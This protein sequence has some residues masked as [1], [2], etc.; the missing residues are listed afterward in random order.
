MTKRGDTY[1]HTLLVHGARA[2]VRSALGKDDSRSR[3]IAALV[4]RRVHNKAVVAVANKNVRILWAML[5]NGECCR[6]VAAAS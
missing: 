1:L 5:T 4:Q 2:A 3:W 6:S